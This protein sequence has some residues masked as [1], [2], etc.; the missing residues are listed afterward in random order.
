MLFTEEITYQSIF[1]ALDSIHF[2]DDMDHDFDGIDL[3]F[4]DV[5]ITRSKVY[6]NLYSTWS[7][8]KPSPLT[9]PILTTREYRQFSIKKWRE[10]RKRRSFKKRVYSV[11]MQRAITKRHRNSGRFIENP[12]F[13]SITE[14]Y[15]REKMINEK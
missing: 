11:N 9:N 4:D 6:K 14:L 3:N 5:T 13:I 7:K 2:F 8:D 12:K 15:E 10:K 1:G